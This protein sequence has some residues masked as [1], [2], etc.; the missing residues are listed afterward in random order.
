MTLPIPSNVFVDGELV[1][2]AKLYTRV[3]SP[4]N[5][6]YATVSGLGVYNAYTPLLTATTT[7]PTLNN[8]TLTGAY[9]QIG[10]AVFWKLKLTIG[11]TFSV[12]SGIYLFSLPATATETDVMCGSGYIVNGSLRKPVTAST[13]STTVLRI[14]RAS[15]ETAVDNTG[16]GAAWATGN[17]V[18]LTG[19]YEA[20]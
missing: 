17:I 3:F 13:N 7:N 6:I 18:T 1:N 8:S 5:T 14:T 16:P 15:N 10:K 2:E 20:A 19:V 4:I 12:G 9:W 11:S